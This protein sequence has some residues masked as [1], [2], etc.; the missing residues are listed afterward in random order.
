MG[1]MTCMTYYCF[2]PR[3]KL[4]PERLKNKC[5]ITSTGCWEWQGAKSGCGYGSVRIDGRTIGV[6]RLAYS[7]FVGPI[8]EGL[9]LD[10]LCR[11]IVC[12]N[13]EH[14]DAVTRAENMRR[15]RLVLCRNS[16]DDWY[17]VRQGGRS[18]RLCRTCRR[19]Y[20]RVYM[21]TYRK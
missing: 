7:L 6:H 12:C 16:H 8:P 9:E 5:I 14:L 15:R 11:N 21:R 17:V 2:I 13:P 18:K 20:H 19:E 4:T 1:V 10:H 3:P